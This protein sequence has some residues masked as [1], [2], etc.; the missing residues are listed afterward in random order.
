MLIQMG[1]LAPILTSLENSTDI[2]FGLIESMGKSIL[3]EGAYV[4][5]F[6]SFS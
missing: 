4:G 2:V 6:H 3:R 5:S 1:S